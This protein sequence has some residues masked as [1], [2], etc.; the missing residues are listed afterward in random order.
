MVVS[1]H[2]VVAPHRAV[3]SV[4]WSWLRVI[5]VRPLSVRSVEWSASTGRRRSELFAGKGR[6]V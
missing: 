5:R 6:Q 3:P 2:A 4:P 1:L